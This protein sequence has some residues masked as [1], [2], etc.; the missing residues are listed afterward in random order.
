MRDLLF[1]KYTYRPR[2]IE[3]IRSYNR[4]HIFYFAS[5]MI[6]PLRSTCL[7]LI[8]AL[9]LISSISSQAEAA[10][11]SVG[12]RLSHFSFESLDERTRHTRTLRDKV[13]VVSVSDKDSSERLQ[14]WLSGANIALLKRRLGL[15][16]AYLNIA[17]VTIIPGIFKGFVRGLMRDASEESREKMR[18]R[19]RRDSIPEGT[20]FRWA[21]LIP[22]WEG[23]HL[24]RLGVEDGERFH[25]WIVYQGRVIASLPEGDPKLT[26]RYLSA[27]EK[28]K[29]QLRESGALSAL[30]KGQ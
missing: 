26:L 12:A 11:L 15:K 27:M 17:D 18:A 5:L 24:T 28:L 19:L 23:D 20:L 9:I 7:T 14:S 16:I 2:V 6:H 21:H 4:S 30:S 10:P 22:D 29:A 13:W 3:M 25:C 8:S 1:K